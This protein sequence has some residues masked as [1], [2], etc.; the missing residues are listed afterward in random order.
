MMVE[1]SILIRRCYLLIL[2]VF[3]RQGLLHLLVIVAISKGF[4][5]LMI[6]F[7]LISDR[8]RNKGDCTLQVNILFGPNYDIFV[9]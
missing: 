9:L 7:L 4:I 2:T 3:K 8:D 6:C 1:E 5:K